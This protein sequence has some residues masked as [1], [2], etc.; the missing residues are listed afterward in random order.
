MGWWASAV[1]SGWWRGA[2]VRVCG[3]GVH[4]Y[5]H[6][7][8]EHNLSQNKALPFATPPPATFHH[9]SLPFTALTPRLTIFFVQL[10]VPQRICFALFCASVLQK[11]NV[12]FRGRFA[13]VQKR[14]SFCPLPLFAVGDCRCA[15]SSWKYDMWGEIRF[16]REEEGSDKNVTLYRGGGSE[17]DP[18]QTV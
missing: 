12:F 16:G 13:K 1:R 14:Y 11:E 6:S 8:H 15:V 9:L 4:Q 3:L 17:L 2:C 18:L 5:H 7:Q 10:T